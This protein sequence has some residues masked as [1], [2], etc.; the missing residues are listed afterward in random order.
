M[1]L[2]VKTELYFLTKDGFLPNENRSRTRADGLPNLQ[3]HK[4]KSIKVE[5]HAGKVR[6]LEAAKG[7]LAK[8]AG[9][10]RVRKGEAAWHLTTSSQQAEGP[11]E[12]TQEVPGKTSSEQHRSTD[13]VRNFGPGC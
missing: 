6:K 13:E 7:A 2:N 10:L 3:T 9:S 8:R 11:P 12:Q 5:G 4:S 1:I